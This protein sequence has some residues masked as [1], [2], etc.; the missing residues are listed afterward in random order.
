MRKEG[1]KER[2]ERGGEEGRRE[3]G[4]KAY[5]AVNHPSVSLHEHCRSKVLLWVPPVGG[6]GCA[7]TET[8]DTLVETILIAC[9]RGEGERGGEGW[10]GGEGVGK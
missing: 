3:G 8:Q 4:V 6:A 10:R 1:R 9:V 7:A 2:G 5:P